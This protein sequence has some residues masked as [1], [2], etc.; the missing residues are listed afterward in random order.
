MY[1]LPCILCRRRRKRMTQSG[2]E[3]AT[4]RFKVQSVNHSAN[5]TTHTKSNLI[6]SIEALGVPV[7]SL[8]NPT[9]QK[10]ENSKTRR[11]KTLRFKTQLFKTLRF[12]TLRFKNPTIQKPYDSKPRL[13]EKTPAIRKN[14]GY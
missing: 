1:V 5:P 4:C 13:L 11:F 8:K 7:S 6:C 9:I 2:F 12:K 3:L 14:P 10:P